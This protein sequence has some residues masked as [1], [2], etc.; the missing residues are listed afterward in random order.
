MSA[1]AWVATA[2]DIISAS[3]PGA[4]HDTKDI[5]FERMSN[6]ENLINTMPGVQ[7]AYIMQA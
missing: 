4:R 5:F 1:E 6:L 7:K 2:A 3:R